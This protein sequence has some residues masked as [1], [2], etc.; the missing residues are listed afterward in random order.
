MKY[1]FIMRA[2][3]E[4][5]AAGAEI[6]F[7]EVIEAMGRYNE[8]L[9]EAGALVTADGLTEPSEGFVVDFASTPPAVVDGAY[10]PTEST[11]NGF[12]IIEAATREEA[13]DWAARC[14]LGPDTKLE[15]RPIHGIEDFPEDNEWV[16]KEKQWIAD[17]EAA[18]QS[19]A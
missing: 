2:T 3:D 5:Q 14:P 11:F 4:A 16:Q 7:E 19:D 18:K 6:P 8:A 1:M 17:A 12:W 9:I 13:A 15:V 10:G